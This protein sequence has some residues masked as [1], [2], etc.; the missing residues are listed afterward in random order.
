MRKWLCL[1]FMHWLFRLSTECNQY[2]LVSYFYV[3]HSK[4]KKEKLD[5]SH[6]SDAY[7]M[8][9]HHHINAKAAQ[10]KFVCSRYSFLYFTTGYYLIKNDYKMLFL[11]YIK[12]LKV[13]IFCL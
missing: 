4:L 8:Q 10:K 9:L 5:Q 7:M 2:T 13:K 6:V 3:T 12:F 11:V 1:C